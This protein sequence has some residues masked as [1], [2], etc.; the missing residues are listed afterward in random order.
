[1]AIMQTRRRFLTTL[2]L[3]GAAGLMPASPALAAAE[4][5]ETTTLR[6]VRVPAICQAP[7][8]IAEDLLRSD[9]F[10]DI[11]YVDTPTDAIAPAVGR[12]EADF[13]LA[14]AIDHIQ[15]IDTG[16]PIVLLGGVHVGCF[17]LLGRESVRSI[18]DLKG[19]SV[20]V[21]LLGSP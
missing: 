14:A 20:G 11:R 2:S 7:L 16:T 19:K 12:G 4:P 5:L 9:G 3:A 6:L 15:A 21:D 8:Y 17:E 1:M 18:T 13:G 10:T